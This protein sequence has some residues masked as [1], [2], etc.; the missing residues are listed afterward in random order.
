MMITGFVQLNID[1]NFKRYHFYNTKAIG[2]NIPFSY[3]LLLTTI[4]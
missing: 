3:V 2:I 1:A 4:N